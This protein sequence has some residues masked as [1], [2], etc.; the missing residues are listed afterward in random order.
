[1]SCKKGSVYSRYWTERRARDDR[2]ELERPPGC[3]GRRPKGCRRNRRT[4]PSDFEL[5]EH[6]GSYRTFRRVVEQTCE[7]GGGEPEWR[8][9]DHP[10][11]LGGPWDLTEVLP[12]DLDLVDQTRLAHPVVELAS[13]V[14]VGFDRDDSSAGSSQWKR[15]GTCASPY[16]DYE[17]TGTGMDR[18]NEP[19]DLTS[20][21]EEVLS[22]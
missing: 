18:L 22:E 11:G 6:I 20:I 15:Q 9:R 12:Y 21:N 13:P 7:Q 14:G 2:T 5:D 19:A 16:F 4:L 10:V 8:I 3:P 17:F 1:M